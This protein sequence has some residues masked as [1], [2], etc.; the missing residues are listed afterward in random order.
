MKRVFQLFVTPALIFIFLFLSCVTPYN[1][2]VQSI[3]RALVVEGM[4]TDQPGPYLVRLTYTADYTYTGLNLRVTG[5]T[6]TIS[7]N[8]GLSEVLK[9]TEEGTYISS[10][11]GLRGIAGRTYTLTIRTREGKQYRSDPELLK[12]AVPI[13]K[14][15]SEYEYDSRGGSPDK[16]NQ[17]NVYVDLKDP[18]TPGDYYR[19]QWV[20]YEF[21]AACSTV[22]RHPVNNP[23]PVY[24]DYPCCTYCWDVTRCYECLTIGSDV[25]INGRSLSR[26][27]VAVVPFTSTR[28]YYLEVEQQSISKGA[29]LFF[30]SV[31]KLINN[32]GGLFDTAPAAVVGNIRSLS[33]PDEPVYGYFGAAGTTVM[34]IYVDRTN[35]V[36][37]PQTMRQF[38]FGNPLRPCR[39]CD[40]LPYRTS[41]QPRW[42]EW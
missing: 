26:Q 35:A 36:G 28:K 11:N 5:A 18:E 41:V 15:Y 32:S 39:T 21:T 4:I 20:H 33:N 27:P 34:P 14:I 37:A 10:G 40:N 23:L 17:W 13:S 6:V 2:E 1:S 30:A 7:D 24:D 19:W 3:G 9:E 16:N 12:A 25:N 38:D 31:K 22:V 29:Y 42:W 8:T